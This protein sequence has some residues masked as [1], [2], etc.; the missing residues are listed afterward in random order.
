MVCA[1]CSHANPPDAR[2]CAACGSRLLLCPECAAPYLS[3]QAFCTACG[4]SLVP[5]VPLVALVAR[6]RPQTATPATD[7]L[8]STD[9]D[10][11]ERRHATVV[12]SDLCGYTA[13]NESL[14]PE[15]VEAIMVR[16]KQAATNVIEAHGGMVNQFIGDEIMALFG[17]PIA[18][19]D[20][21]RRAI[22]AAIALHEAVDLIASRAQA[23]IGRVVRMHTGVN[24]GLVI[25]RPGDHRSGGF[26]LT[27]DTVNTAARLRGL[28]QPGEILVGADTWQQVSDFFDAQACDPV[29]VKGK[30]QPVTPY[31]IRSEAS[32]VSD[33]PLVGRA[34]ELRQFD[35]LV[36][37]CLQRGRGRVIFVRGDP[38]LGKSRLGVEMLRMA[39]DR[40]FTCHSASVLDFGP[41]VGRDM[42]RNLVQSLLG[43]P[44]SAD[45]E[46]CRD[47]VARR[48]AE[49]Q[50][51]QDQALFLYDL[52]DVTPPAELRALL[53]A[54]SS[55]AREKGALQ[56]LSTLV[57][58]IGATTPIA[59][60]VEDIHWADAWTLE[61]LAALVRLAATQPLLLVMT[62]RFA[63]DP[64]VGS[65]RAEVHGAPITSID[66]GPLQVDDAMLLAANVVARSDVL[67]RGFVERA[68]GNP[69]FLEQ[70]MLNSGQADPADLPGSIQ[71]LVHARLDRLAPDDKAAM[72]AASVLGQQFALDALRHLVDDPA[73]DCGLLIEQF[74]VRR[75]GGTLQFCHALIRDGAY[76]S[77]LHSRQRRLHARAAEWFGTR[78]VALSAEH[79]ERAADARAIGAYLAA[80][81]AAAKQFR[82]Q[83]ALALAQ[84]G[85]QLASQRSDRFALLMAS[86]RW[87]L[88]LGR[89]REAIDCC[90]AALALA[91]NDAEKAQA[92]I[93]SAEGMRIVDQIPEGLAALDQAEPLA[94]EA[95]LALEL[96]RLHHLRGNLWFPQGRLEECLHEHQQALARAQEAGSHEAQA[97][98]LG[99]LGD[100][101]YLRG[102][103]R[104]AHEQFRRCVALSREHGYGRLEVTVLH[105]VGWT[106]LHLNAVHDA[107]EVGLE[108]VEL[109]VH[110]SHPRA[111]LLARHLVAH[112]DG[113][114]R[115]NSAHGLRQLDAALPLA[116]ALGAKRF[117]AQHWTLR[118]MLEMR[119]GDPLSARTHVDMALAICKEHGMGFIGPMAYGVLASLE[120]DPGARRRAMAEGEAQLT[121]GS[122]SHNHIS[123][124]DFGIDAALRAGEWQAAEECCRQLEDYT[125]AE[126]LPQSDFLVRRG[127]ALVRFGRGLGDP[128]VLAELSGLRE[129]AL[130]LELHVSLPALESALDKLPAR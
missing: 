60:L 54:I 106:A 79:F 118:A 86:A 30:E 47:A 64:T 67:L 115:G 101:Y 38:G 26:T 100:A 23:T 130:R 105:M 49:R 62:T 94:R 29:E 121:K 36:E 85:Q 16:V 107:C 33:R 45:E 127:R 75:N 17:I 43:L 78:D 59:M 77:L 55:G 80:S 56:A 19:R 69:L 129:E 128:S 124:R 91:A 22:R 73:Y 83:H 96:S 7:T 88:E 6:A 117:E 15:E 21:A 48:A 84:R 44:P 46:S 20:D 119:L 93:Q 18:R 39:R 35:M 14:D 31:R 110:A 120:T 90:T 51:A 37:A 58:N 108:A 82:Y 34:D 99:G 76:A 70:L 3:D 98:A 112:V 65:W 12:F 109:A 81:H 74:L 97:V 27:G 63:G 42:I 104:S 24:T 92:L 2:F 68:E 61:R 53:A 125:A 41:Q 111:E 116:R 1:S 5:L 126:S 8:P 122:V 114:I 87:L 89:A 123:L 102:H 95:G 52:V 28:A 71:S 103:M 32:R 11:G 25:A 66:L 40:G 9:A 57:S 4:H 10:A 113:W 72:Q 50:M 13:L